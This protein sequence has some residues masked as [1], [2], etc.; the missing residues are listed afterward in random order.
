[1]KPLDANP[2]YESKHPGRPKGSTKK[3]KSKEELYS[4]T[5]EPKDPWDVWKY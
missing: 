1:M 5:N 4:I 2:R 3:N